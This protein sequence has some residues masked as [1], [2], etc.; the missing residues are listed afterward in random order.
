MEEQNTSREKLEQSKEK[1]FS[2]LEDRGITREEVQEHL[3]KELQ[4]SKDIGM[5]DAN[6][7]RRALVATINH[8]RK[9]LDKLGNRVKFLCLGVS[10]PTDY[11]LSNK[12]RELKKRFNDP[13]IRSLERDEL[14]DSGKIS[15][16]GV[17]LHTKDTTFVEDK[18]GS[19]INLNEELRQTMYGLAETKDG[20]VYKAIVQLFGKSACDAEKI[21][22]Q[23]ALVSGEQGKS[24][25]FPDF[26]VLNTRDPLMRKAKDSS[27]ISIEKYKELIQQYFPNDIIDCSAP[28]PF[29]KLEEESIEG[30]TFAFLLNAKLL[31][32]DF[33]QY[34]ATTSITSAASELDV[35][36]SIY[37]D[38]NIQSHIEITVDP[39]LSHETILMVNSRKKRPQDL[40]LKLDV[41]GMFTEH[42][43]DPS[44][45]KLESFTS[46][47]GLSG[48]IDKSSSG[49]EEDSFLNAIKR[50]VDGG[51]Q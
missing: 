46:S 18:I 14:V 13:N 20:K 47:D 24:K 38:V 31:N 29:Q 23:W 45:F 28:S 49:N 26:I 39:K 2:E 5:E 32:Y 27:V 17:P 12:V 7:Y 1:L 15:M 4:E 22:Y 42:P 33:S 21:N 10:S 11:G 34:G 41:L 36:S 50:N 3:N 16:D 6:G 30:Q 9:Y 44:Q 43:M 25:H 37:A 8:Y 40:R 48:Q 51:N 35:T 19:P